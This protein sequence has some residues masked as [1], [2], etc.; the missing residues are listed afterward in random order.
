[1]CPKTTKN[2]S[3]SSSEEDDDETFVGKSYSQTREKDKADSLTLL[4]N[5]NDKRGMEFIS[6]F[7]HG[8]ISLNQLI[9]LGHVLSAISRIPLPRDF[10]R[11]KKL[12]MAWF[13]EHVLEL[14]P[15]K[16][17]IQVVYHPNEGPEIQPIKEAN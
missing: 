14:M 17:C 8:E 4:Y 13:N 1:M 7:F 3:T 11:R 12:M 16:N 5:P 2:L 9:S 15:Y 10:T 6:L